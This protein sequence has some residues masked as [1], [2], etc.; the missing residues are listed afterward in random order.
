MCGAFRT[1][2]SKDKYTGNRLFIGRL[3]QQ[4]FSLSQYG[5]DAN[6]MIAVFQ[7]CEAIGAYRDLIFIVV[8]RSR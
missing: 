6:S 4:S 1:N 5:Y 3:T 2:N 7:R 8:G